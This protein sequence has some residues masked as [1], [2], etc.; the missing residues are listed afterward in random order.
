META[1]AAQKD[2]FEFES[3]WYRLGG[4]PS[5]EIYSQFGMS[6]RAFFEQLHT[7][8]DSDEALDRLGPRDAEVMRAVIRRR[9][10][11]AR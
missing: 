11:L 4:G 10:W 5:E 3:R 9:L 2:M 1:T 6:D 8:V 7:L